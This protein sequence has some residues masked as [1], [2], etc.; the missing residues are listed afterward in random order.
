MDCDYD[1]SGA[2][3]NPARRRQKVAAQRRG[4]NVPL[5]LLFFVMSAFGT[6]LAG[7]FAPNVLSIPLMR[8]EGVEVATD[9]GEVRVARVT[10]RIR[11]Q[12]STGS[13]VVGNLTAGDSVRVEPVPN[14][15]FRVYA[16][17]L[18]PRLR[19]KPLGFIYGTLLVETGPD[20]VNAG[21]TGGR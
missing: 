3:A 10:S 14:G 4:A 17:D 20:V 5:V 9:W 19:A 16:A 8:G 6:V 1:G 21:L 7:V 15:W 18:V 2:R 12:A 11:A 13:H